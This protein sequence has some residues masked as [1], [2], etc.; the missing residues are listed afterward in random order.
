MPGPL[1]LDREAIGDLCRKHGVRSLVVF[2]SALTEHFDDTCSDVDFLVK[3]ADDLTS[4]FDAYFGLKEGLETL[5][6][7]PVDLVMPGALDNPYF[8]AS[9]LRR[10]EELYAA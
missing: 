8:A 4:R 7:R 2:G 10:S 5:L 3:F 9:I 6:G 1:A